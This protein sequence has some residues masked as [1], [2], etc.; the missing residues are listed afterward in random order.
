M[1]EGDEVQNIDGKNKT[2]RKIKYHRK[3]EERLYEIRHVLEFDPNRKR[4]SVLIKNLQA[5]EYALL[6]K[7]ADNSI[8]SAS[9]CGNSYK[10]AQSLK[11][12]SEKG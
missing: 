9:T 1:Y 7:G 2:V 10:Y 5:H 4:M 11:S 6:C 12:F 3:N 8:F